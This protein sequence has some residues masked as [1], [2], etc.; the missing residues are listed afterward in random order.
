MRR[1][2]LFMTSDTTDV[3]PVSASPAPASTMPSA[4]KK[5]QVQTHI[6][7]PS[8]ALAPFR[9][10][11]AVQAGLSRGA[12]FGLGG[13]ALGEWMGGV[14]SRTEGAAGFSKLG[15][16]TLGGMLGVTGFI[17]GAYIAMKQAQEAARQHYA[18][19]QTMTQMAQALGATLPEGT[20]DAATHDGRLAE[21]LQRTK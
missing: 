12:L 13:Y 18:M 15:H 20:V 4:E 9:G 7:V 8:D 6:A 21:P 16:H 3:P 2:V 5:P 1:S 17:V 11:S 19:K 14:G 10:V